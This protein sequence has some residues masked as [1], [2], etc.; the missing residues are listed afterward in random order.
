MD[1]LYQLALE[2]TDNPLLPLGDDP[3]IV[4]RSLHNLDAEVIGHDDEV[5]VTVDTAP[6]NGSAKISVTLINENT[7]QITCDCE[8]ELTGDDDGNPLCERRVFSLHHIIPLPARV[9]P[10]GAKMSLRNGVLDIHLKKYQQ[11]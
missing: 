3:D 4:C 9:I 7:L 8:E 11:A 5:M 2:P 6:G 1:Y 10:S